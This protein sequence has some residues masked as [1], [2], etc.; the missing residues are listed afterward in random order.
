MDEADRTRL[1]DAE[2][3]DGSGSENAVAEYMTEINIYAAGRQGIVFEI[4]KVFNEENIAIKGMN[5]RSNKQGK[6]T[7]SIQFAVKSKDQL[8]VLSSK[9]RNVNGIIDIE[10]TTG[11]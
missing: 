10:R 1:I 11:S 5:V 4:S 9:I 8:A 3:E 6:M 7:I 2:W